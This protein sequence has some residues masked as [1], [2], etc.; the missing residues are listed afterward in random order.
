MRKLTLLPVILVALLLGFNS[1]KKDTV[2]VTELLTTVPSSAGGV[3]VLNLEGILEDAGCKIKNHAITP[4]KELMELIN[5]KATS[6]DKQDFMFL[7]EGG[8]GIEPKGAVIFYDANRT[9]VTCALYDVDK[10][11][12]FV[13]EKNGGSF[14]DEGSGVKVN[15]QVA[16]KGSQA[17]VSLNNRRNIDPG[18]IANYASLSPSQSFLV[19]PNGE[20]LLTEE[21]DIRGW[22]MINTFVNE[23]L[24]RSE[25]SMF[26]LGLGFL[27]EDAESVRFKMDFK[28][29]EME[30]E[31]LVLNDKGKPAKYLLPSDKV[32]VNTLK[33]LG[34]NCDAMMA[35]TVNPK[36]IKKFDQVL[37]AFGGS[38]FGNL[39]DM[40][41]NVDGTVGF[42]SGVNSNDAVNG[43]IT[44]KGDVSK[45]LK[46]LITNQIAPVS[47]DGKYLRFS[48][49]NVDGHL[50][51][52]EAADELKGCC[53][54]IITDASGLNNVGY[55][56]AAP[57][58]MQTIVF[59]FNPESGGIEMELEI[60]TSNPKENALLTLIK[61]TK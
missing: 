60:K 4:S 25:R 5:S 18:A 51:I 33:T 19:T 8:S 3:V 48:K 21:D 15:G 52:S 43:V 9:Y 11:I 10:F 1:C 38:L 17:W 12:K 23:I 45:D 30:A 16:V 37:S 36:L 49:G 27:F 28:N 39:N 46:D 55:S 26:T 35:L 20:K 47:Q 56:E 58:G 61:N 14:T 40:F 50:K 24:N 44:T 42:A 2:D 41:K 32:D 13:E 57:T 34:E 6:T 59:K 53:L 29:G 22:A 31:A 7:L 54:G